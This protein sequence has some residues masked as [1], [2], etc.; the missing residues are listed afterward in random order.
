MG[1]VDFTKT[2]KQDKKAHGFGVGIVDKIVNKYNGI[3]TRQ[4]LETER[5]GIGYVTI[6]IN[7]CL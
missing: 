1:T 5:A 4:C 6:S 2:S 7:I 3:V